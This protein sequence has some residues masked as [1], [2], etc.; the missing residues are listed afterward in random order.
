MQ[1]IGAKSDDWM[2]CLCGNEPDKE[3]FYP[4]NVNG[5][6]VE[7]TE[8]SWNGDL[9]ACD[10]C[11]RIIGRS[12]LQVQGVRAGHSLSQ[13]DIEHIFNM[14]QESQPSSQGQTSGSS[15]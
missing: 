12:S 5:E 15:S 4:C 6:M 11:G 3:G 9:Y 14:L 13:E 1:F 2:V 7:P 10:G 8:E